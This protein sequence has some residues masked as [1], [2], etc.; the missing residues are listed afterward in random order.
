M[1]TPVQVQQGSIFSPEPL[2][3]VCESISAAPRKGQLVGEAKLTKK[4]PL[5]DSISRTFTI[6][7]ALT[8]K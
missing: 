5:D 6:G 2:A 3:M 8:P 7:A 4:V 1:L